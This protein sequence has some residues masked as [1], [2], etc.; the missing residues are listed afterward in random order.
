MRGVCAACLVAA[1]VLA[2][3][4]A[5]VAAVANRTIHLNWTERRQ[6]SSPPMRFRVTEVKVTGNRWSVR[7]SFTNLGKTAL[8][9]EPEAWKFP[10]PSY[11]FSII[12]IDRYPDQFRSVNAKTS[13]PHLP[14]RIGAGKTWSGT[15]GGDGATRLPHGVKLYISF[16][17][18]VDPSGYGFSWL[19][20]HS[21]RL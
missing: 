9:I 7:A 21:F 20:Q 8:T 19:T 2:P 12:A 3:Y 13:S 16:G 18:F 17:H 14:A 15:F 5:A 6:Y 4:S 1:A 11:G 10:T